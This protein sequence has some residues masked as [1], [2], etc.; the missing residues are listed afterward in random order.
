VRLASPYLPRYN[1]ARSDSRP[2]NPGKQMLQIAFRQIE[3]TDEPFLWEM[4]YHALHVP[5]GAAP[6]SREIVHEP[7]IA[8]YVKAWGRAGDSGWV[9]SV[10]PAGKL[11]GAA[12]LRQFTAAQPGYGFVDEQTPELSVALLPEYRGLGLGTQLLE[13]LI[14]AAQKDSAALSLSVSRDSPSRR[15]YERVGFV[16]IKNS[17]ASFTMRKPLA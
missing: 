8:Q 13:R 14:G 10:E 2:V 3:L 11:A 16:T 15:L 4:L 6:F 5:E 7:G 17:G 12:W 9:V 1:A